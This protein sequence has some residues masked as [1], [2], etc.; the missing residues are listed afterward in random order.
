MAE[1]DSRGWQTGSG[2]QGDPEL[3]F[4][5]PHPTPKPAQPYKPPGP[6]QQLVTR[7]GAG[8]RQSVMLLP[9]QSFPVPP[10]P[11][12]STPS[13]PMA[14]CR[15]RTQGPWGFTHRT[16]GFHLLGWE[17]MVIFMGS[18]LHPNMHFPIHCIN[19]V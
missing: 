2:H 14:T 15:A 18:N 5:P 13:S 6:R 16:E 9:L 8:L 10:K 4:Q 17:K 1:K 3:K 12:L 19:N 11:G 7:R